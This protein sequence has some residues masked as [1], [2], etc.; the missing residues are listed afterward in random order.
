[1]WLIATVTYTLCAFCPPCGMGLLLLCRRGP[2]ILIVTV[3]LT[4]LWWSLI[5]RFLSVSGLMWSLIVCVYIILPFYNVQLVFAIG[6]VL[7][8]L[9]ILWYIFQKQLKNKK[10]EILSR[11]KRHHVP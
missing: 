6:A 8:I 11:Y 9:I 2:V 3:V 4:R 5:P 10:D 1:M 7:Q